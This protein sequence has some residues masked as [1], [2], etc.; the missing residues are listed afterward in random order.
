MQTKEGAIKTKATIT[1][2]YG[3]DYWAKIGAQGGS[4]ATPTS[5]KRKGFGANPELA[6][7]AG[8]KGGSRKKK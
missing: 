7:I 1:E 6:R 8:R 5:N 2:K 4:S 3:K